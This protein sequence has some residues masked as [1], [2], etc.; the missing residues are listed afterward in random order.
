MA[1]IQEI[2][3][4]I[5]GFN[6]DYEISNLGRIASLLNGRYILKQTISVRGYLTVNLK[7]KPWKTYT[8]HRFIAKAFIPNPENKSD[9]NHKNGI[10]TDNRIENLEW[11]TSK[12]NNSHARATGLINLNGDKC[13]TSKLTW[14]KVNFIRKKSM[15][16]YK[17]AKKFGVRQPTIS[18]IQAMKTWRM[19][20]PVIV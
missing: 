16:Q 19:K 20:G 10:K 15:T 3:K 18:K 7:G 5:P 8:T 6:G 9:V 13:G 11:C 1:K 2:W 12:E 4:P 17:L 14:S